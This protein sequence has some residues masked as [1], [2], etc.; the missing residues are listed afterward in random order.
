MKTKQFFKLNKSVLVFP[1][2]AVIMLGM[3]GAT[4]AL[5]SETLKINV[6]VNT[7]ELKTCFVRA[8]LSDTENASGVGYNDYVGV[9]EVPPGAPGTIDPNISCNSF[10]NGVAVVHGDLDYHQ[11][12]KDYAWG[13]AELDD[14][15]NDGNNDTVIVV[16]HNVYPGYV[17][18]L[19]VEVENAGTIPLYFDYYIVNGTTLT[20]QQVGENWLVFLDSDGDCKPELAV[21]LIDILGNQIDPGDE[22]EC[23][24]RFIVLQDANETAT[25]KIFIRLVAVQWSESIYNTPS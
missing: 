17:T 12:D 6:T 24:I 25:Y 3:M 2:L 14:P 10:N 4:F 18:W 9:V 23:S 19:S 13:T 20:A 11:S 15:D 8:Y 7:G 16:L 22:R 5:W 21:Q 1:I